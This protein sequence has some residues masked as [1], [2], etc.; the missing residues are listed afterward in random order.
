MVM[1]TPVLK[2]PRMFNNVMAIDLGCMVVLAD[3]V[4]TLIC[5]SGGLGL[6]LRFVTKLYKVV[7]ETE[8][9]G[10]LTAPQFLSKIP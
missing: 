3:K 2:D 1:T 6:T 8:F 4:L 10:V 9:L 7:E 5:L